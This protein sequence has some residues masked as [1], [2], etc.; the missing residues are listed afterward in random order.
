MDESTK[1]PKKQEEEIAPNDNNNSDS[2]VKADVDDSSSQSKDDDGQQKQQ[3]QKQKEDLETITA[4]IAEL[5]ARFA[6]KREDRQA[7]DPKTIDYPDESFFG[8][9]DS[10]I[11]KNTAFVKKLRNMTEAGRELILKDLASLNL[12]RY[13][14]ELA[15]A[16]VETKLKLTDIGLAVTV[17]SLLHRRYAEFS[18]QLLEAWTKNL[19][20]KPT[21]PPTFNAA[22]M[23]IDVRLFTELILAGVFGP[24]PK[25]ALSLLGAVLTVLTTGDREAHNNLAIVLGFV[26]QYGNEFAGLVPRRMR[27]LAEAH[28]LAVPIC[29]FLSAERQKGVRHLLKEY[30]ASLVGHLHRDDKRLRGMEGE[31]R[32]VL[33]TRG[34]VAK[35]QKEAYEG[36]SVEFKKLWA[37]AEQL[38]D[39]LDEELPAF[40][41]DCTGEGFDGDEQRGD[42]VF[43]F[44]NRFRG[45]GNGCPQTAL[46][47]D[48]ETRTFYESL[49]DL[50]SIIPAILYKDSL[51]DGQQ[52][53]QQ[54]ATSA[55]TDSSSSATNSPDQQQ[56]PLVNGTADGDSTGD[57]KGTEEGAEK[58]ADGDL[59]KAV[60]EEEEMEVDEE[61]F[62][63]SGKDMATLNE[64]DELEIALSS[65]QKTEQ[66]QQQKNQ[67][68]TAVET[69]SSEVTA[70]TTTAAA[71]EGK[72]TATAASTSTSTTKS[73]IDVF[74]ASLLKCVNRDFIDKAAL[75]FAT[76]YNTK[77][78]RKKLVNVLF[79]VPRTR[80][81]LLPFY[82][83]FVAQL[84]P[85]MP[86][87]GGDLVSLLKHNF[88]YL[89]KKKDQINIESKVKNIRFIGE[90]VKFGV[91]PK[92][93]ALYILKVSLWSSFCVFKTNFPP[94]SKHRPCS[95]TF[96]TTTLRWPAICWRRRGSTCTA[97]PTP[98]R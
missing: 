87:V 93:D 10:S 3:Q 33:V 30:F 16:L 69:L 29:D 39:L 72:K 42:V 25:E 66:K 78:N 62:A 91:F 76:T 61:D 94:L 86:T 34:E 97:A 18:G 51:K 80:L 13:V 32:R 70:T 46:W 67:S 90:L 5:T 40:S 58:T 26:R 59:E 63:D 9:L 41:R 64:N 27:L 89:F 88:R 85:I 73:P 57:V 54:I 79:T 28:G 71:E 24:A 68:L 14:S 12:S 2:G 45:E 19:P 81:D 83:R 22:K 92:P 37:T 7:N 44:S 48:E 95:L 38:A 47:E 65:I 84:S 6:A 50:K 56:Q 74:F 20:R 96:V 60:G 17:C 77:T 35:H 52:Q 82:A 98:I 8:R 55:T 4:F 21:D 36:R 43:D 23:R 31:M 15:S 53:Q 75:T 1:N 11:K 49:P